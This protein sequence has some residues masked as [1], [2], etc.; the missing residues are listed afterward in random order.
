MDVFFGKLPCPFPEKP[1]LPVGP[2]EAMGNPFAEYD[3]FS[4]NPESVGRRSGTIRI[5]HRCTYFPNQGVGQYFVVIETEYPIAAR[6]GETEV[7]V[8][9]EH[10]VVLP[11]VHLFGKLFCNR[12]GIVRRFIVHN[13]NLIR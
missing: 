8:D 12:D 2:P 3:I 13:N 9:I 6:F 7:F 10:Q 5:V 1:Q 4:G 11:A